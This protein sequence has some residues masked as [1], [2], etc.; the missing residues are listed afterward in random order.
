M[1]KN[2]EQ[3]VIEVLTILG[4]I[5]DLTIDQLRTLLAYNYQKDGASDEFVEE[6]W[7]TDSYWEVKEHLIKALTEVFGY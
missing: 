3:E 2:L 5:N 7:Q 6:V 4:N 1:L